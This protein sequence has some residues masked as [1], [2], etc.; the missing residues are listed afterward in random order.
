[1]KCMFFVFFY[2][3]IENSEMLCQIVSKLCLE[4]LTFYNSTFTENENIHGICVRRKQLTTKLVISLVK[5]SIQGLSK[6]NTIRQ[7]LIKSDLCFI[8]RIEAHVDM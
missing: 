4:N 7:L 3:T 2:I 6:L 5:A 8:F 1:M